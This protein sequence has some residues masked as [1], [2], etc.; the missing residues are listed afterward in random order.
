MRL[1]LVSDTHLRHPELPPGDILVHAGDLTPRGTLVELKQALAWLKRQPH[2]HKVVIAGNH[3]F[4]LEEEP[5]LRELF[6]PGIHYLRDEEREAAG[7]RFFG[8]PW[9]PWFHD[10]AFNLPRG[11][12]LREVW[13]QIPPE[14]DVLVTHG[15]PARILD[16]THDGRHVGCEDLRRAVEEK[17][18]RLHVFGHIHEAYGIERAAATTF[19]NAST[20]DLGYRAVHAPLVMELAPQV[21]VA[22][23]RGAT[24][25]AP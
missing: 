6:E 22:S 4:C 3:D 18:P 17:R 13:A 14:L 11:D 16:R 15:P 7:L 9:T 20:C 2:E 21:S 10:W 23:P 19:V 24:E 25:A 12:A 5:G 8:S 1:V